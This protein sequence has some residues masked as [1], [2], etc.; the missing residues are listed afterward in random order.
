MTAWGEAV[1][2]TLGMT[3]RGEAVTTTLGMTAWGEAVITVIADAFDG[4]HVLSLRGFCKKPRQS[5]VLFCH[6]EGFLTPRQSPAYVSFMQGFRRV[7]GFSFR[8]FR[9]DMIK[10]L[11]KFSH[12]TA[13]AHN[14]SR[15]FVLNAS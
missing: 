14:E 5:P 8:A 3:V 10:F 1:T 15:F 7:G 6:C 4:H 12:S 2:P 13:F 11:Q 9:R